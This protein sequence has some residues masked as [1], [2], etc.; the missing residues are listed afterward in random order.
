MSTEVKVYTPTL[1]DLCSC[2]ALRTPIFQRPYGWTPE[3]AVEYFRDFLANPKA[4]NL[5]GSV[6]GYCQTPWSRAA[7]SANEMFVTDGQHRLV[8]STVVAVA[9]LAERES[10]LKAC[11]A[12]S[13][14]S[15]DTQ[16]ILGEL[17]RNQDHVDALAKI[18]NANIEFMVD[19]DGTVANLRTFLVESDARIKAL[20]AEIEKSH[21]HL[22]E[23]RSQRTTRNIPHQARE[24]LQS[25]QRT[26]GLS[27][28]EERELAQL[29]SLTQ[30]ILAERAVVA[31]AVRET[32]NEEAN[33]RAKIEQIATIPLYAAFV[34]IREHLDALS[35]SALYRHFSHYAERQTTFSLALLILEPKGNNDVDRIVLDDQAAEIFAQINGQTRPLTSPELLNSLF[36]SFKGFK[37]DNPGEIAER[38]KKS[39]IVAFDGESLCDYIA[40][41]ESK[42]GNTKASQWVR[43]LLAKVRS[44]GRSTANDAQQ[45]VLNSLRALDSFQ[46]YV[47]DTSNPSLTGYVDLYRMLVRIPVSSLWVLV[48]RVWEA[49]QANPHPLAKSNAVK[50][51]FKMLLLLRVASY[52]NRSTINLTRDLASKL[53]LQEAFLYVANGLGYKARGEAAGGHAI[54]PDL[55][56]YVRTELHDTLVAGEFGLS[57]QRNF[58]RV[59]LAVADFRSMGVKLSY[60][61]V[62]QFEFEHVLPQAVESMQIGP[63]AENDADV[64]QAQTEIE[65]VLTLDEKARVSLINR[66]GNGALL[67]KSSNGSLGKLAPLEKLRAIDQKGMHNGYWPSHLQ[68]LRD[69]KGIVGQRYIEQRSRDLAEQIVAFLL[70]LSFLTQGQAP[71]LA[72]A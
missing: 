53:S 22:L 58:A 45:A 36:R 13:E 67:E 29:T 25:K 62:A 39:E 43:H 44:V 55:V 6:F 46:S 72:A 7:P 24:R 41:Y 49:E 56:A 70:D 71:A 10:R 34:G 48:A 54:T 57:R 38:V 68:A 63:G 40:R 11:E 23:V 60:T 32:R 12:K 14:L 19:E 37:T 27:E 69:S 8:T 42:D 31:E 28:A 47:L 26:E 15:D 64:L 21:A 35:L 33:L 66:L 20:E 52:S 50:D 2:Q 65:Q 9:L 51:L 1:V 30:E 3:K 4:N 59:L 16:D 5:F 18:A 17:S 61:Q